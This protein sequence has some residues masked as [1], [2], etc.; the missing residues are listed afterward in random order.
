M[1]VVPQKKQPHL[2]GKK[3]QGVPHVGEPEVSNAEVEKPQGHE[4]DPC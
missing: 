3:H 2:D 4:D 1:S